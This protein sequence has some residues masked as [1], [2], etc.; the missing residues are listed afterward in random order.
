[1]TGPGGVP[2]G[3]AVTV[4][5]PV[6]VLQLL[7]AVKAHKAVLTLFFH[8]QKVLAPTGATQAQV[9]MV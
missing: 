5:M 8:A 1:M 6:V 2:S 9:A 4:E 3:H 7:E